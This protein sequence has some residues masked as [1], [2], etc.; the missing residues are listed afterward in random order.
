MTSFARRMPLAGASA[1]AGDFATPVGG[2]RAGAWSGI[3]AD[4]DALAAAV[5]VFD[6]GA[7]TMNLARRMPLAFASGRSDAFGKIGADLD[8][9][10]MRVAA[11]DAGANAYSFGRR[12]PLAIAGGDALAAIGADLDELAARVGN[13]TGAAG[14][15]ALKFDFSAP[16]N[17]SWVFQ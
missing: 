10:T 14:G 5:A 3:G 7:T 2:G 6:S 11:L 13:L 15:A 16:T 4:L 12:F 9:L 1:N 8:T 17:E